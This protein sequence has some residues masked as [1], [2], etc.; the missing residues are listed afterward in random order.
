M[1][2][3]GWKYG[4]YKTPAWLAPCFVSL[5]MMANIFIM[6]GCREDKETKCRPFA[7]SWAPQPTKE[8]PAVAKVNGVPILKSQ[9]VSYLRQHEGCRD[10]KESEAGGANGNGNRDKNRRSHG[11][12]KKAG[13]NEEFGESDVFEKMEETDDVSKDIKKIRCPSPREAL[14]KLINAEL[15]AQ[16][17]RRLD[18]LDKDGL[19]AAKKKAAQL[20]LEIA[21]EKEHQKK[22]VP[23]STLRRSYQL[24]IRH[25]VRPEL[26]QFAHILISYPEQ[27]TGDKKNQQVDNHAKKLDE[28]ALALG[29][30]I[31][32][33]AVALEK[34]DQLDKKSFFNIS[35]E[36]KISALNKGLKIKPEQGTMSR[37]RLVARFADVLFS[38]EKEKAVSEPVKTQFGVH[39]IYL[40]DILPAKDESFKEAKETVLDRVFPEFRKRAFR[41][42]LE[43]L[44]KTCRVELRIENLPSSFIDCSTQ[45]VSPEARGV[46]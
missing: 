2:R 12:E 17:A 21:F 35:D 18:F 7:P 5:L 8:D 34:T 3:N 4:G 44:K 29:W 22:D 14:Q 40:M 25:F 16:E 39:V 1:K 28:K 27:K 10:K 15:L 31:Y 20:V 26:R 37:E 33:K 38:M 11:I 9:L 45:K 19:R 24:N 32:E 41:K 43:E 30:T 46:P 36:Q 6:F 42:Y 23:T 13:G